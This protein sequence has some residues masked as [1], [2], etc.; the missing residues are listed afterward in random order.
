MVMNPDAFLPVFTSVGVRKLSSKDLIFR[1]DW[2]TKGSNRRREEE[3]VYAYYL[4]YV[5][6][7]EGKN[8]VIV[9]GLQIQS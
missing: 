2:S 6:E 7:L 8:K 9:L 4:D 1:V 3:R 5:E